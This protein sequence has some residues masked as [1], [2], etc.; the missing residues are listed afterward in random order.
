MCI[1]NR[2]QRLSRNASL[3]YQSV[4]CITLLWLTLDSIGIAG[5]KSQHLETPRTFRFAI[6]PTRKALLHADMLVVVALLLRL[7]RGCHCWLSHRYFPL[8]MSAAKSDGI[9]TVR[10]IDVVLGNHSFTI[11]SLG[12]ILYW[13]S[14]CCTAST[15]AWSQGTLVNCNHIYI[16]W[17]IF[18]SVCAI[19]ALVTVSIHQVRRHWKAD[20]HGFIVR[21]NA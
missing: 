14:W 1:E 3:R 6:S 15:P 10:I 5:F 21:D 9:Q 12:R 16:L 19:I 7:G 2:T 18:L 20:G 8:R 13:M 4:S 17:Y 11:W